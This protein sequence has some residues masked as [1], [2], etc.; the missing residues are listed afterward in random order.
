MLAQLD[1]LTVSSM[2]SNVAALQDHIPSLVRDTGEERRRQKQK[3]KTNRR[4]AFTIA[5]AFLAVYCLLTRVPLL[6]EVT[7]RSARS[8]QTTAVHE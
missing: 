6:P 8:K 5:R 1:S 2:G 7:M 3:A 4:D